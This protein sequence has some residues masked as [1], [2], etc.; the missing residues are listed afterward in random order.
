M[1]EQPKTFKAWPA[2]AE[3]RI[4]PKYPVYIPSKGRADRC[5]TAVMFDRDQVPFR[6]VVEEAEFDAYASRFGEERVLVLPFSNQGSVIPARNWIKQHSIEE[7]F[8]RHW[9]FD[10]N[11]RTPHRVWKGKRLYCRSGTALR[12]CEDFTDRYTNI[13]IAG[14]NYTMFLPESVPFPPFFLNV[15]VYSCS[16]I[17]NALPNRWRGTYNEDTDYCLQILAD[18][19]CTV[20]LN[21]FLMDKI[22]T[23]SMAGGNTTDLYQGDGRLR[24][25]RALEKNWPGVVETKR[26]WQR[27]Q[28]SIKAGW[29]KFDTPL[30]RKPEY[31][32]LPEKP[33]DYGMELVEVRPVRSARLRGLVEDYRNRLDT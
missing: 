8:E 9:Q 25:A 21:C 30:I 16:L 3:D 28:H 31:E 5:L 6:L 33:N 24:M 27:P 26:R 10:D 17:N 11:I 18:G 15:H 32:D 2:P 12:V 4:L 22:H 20:L 14:F 23:M 1:V 29:R 7:G 13:G 19:Y